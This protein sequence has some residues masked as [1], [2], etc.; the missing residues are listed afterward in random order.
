MVIFNT[1]AIFT[2][3]LKN[4]YNAAFIAKLISLHDGS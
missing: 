2:A 3:T 1:L 4:F